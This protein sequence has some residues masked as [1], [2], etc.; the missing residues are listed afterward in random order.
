MFYSLYQT[1][2]IIW[3]VLKLIIIHFFESRQIEIKTTNIEIQIK[4]Q[5]G[6]QIFRYDLF[7]HTLWISKDKNPNI[8][9]LK[10]KYASLCTTL[11]LKEINLFYEWSRSSCSLHTGSY[12]TFKTYMC[13]PITNLRSQDHN[14]TDTF[15]IT[16]TNFHWCIWKELFTY[17]LWNHKNSRCLNLHGIRG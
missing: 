10:I 1:V 15:F 14:I 5:N 2:V 3:K 17:I 13:T 16:W 7:S 8:L 11:H 9:A 4:M 12:L 6:Q